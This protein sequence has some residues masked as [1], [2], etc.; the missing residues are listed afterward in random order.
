MEELT[1]TVFEYSWRGICFTFCLIQYLSLWL[2]VPLL[3]AYL[4]VCFILERDEIQK[5]TIVLLAYH[6]VLSI[7]NAILTV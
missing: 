7:L 3:I 2:S 5:G 6:F 4:V 1:E